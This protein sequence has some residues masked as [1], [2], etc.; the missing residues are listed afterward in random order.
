MEISVFTKNYSAPPINRKEILRY[1]KAETETEELKKLIDE[2]LKE[3]ETALCYKVV[4]CELPICC[5]NGCL[6]LKF[7][8]SYS[9]S[10]CKNLEGCDRIVL[11]AAT[12]GVKFD[13]LT[14]KYNR[15]SPSKAVCLQA[16]GNERIE[17]LCDAFN[18]DM[19]AKFGLTKPRFSPGY[20]D[21]PLSLQKHIFAVLDCHRKIGLTLNESILMSPQKSV[22]AIIGIKK[23]LE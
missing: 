11:F 8:K 10:L 3:A 2:A 18:S 19:T 17:S 13:M 16:I 7:C 20:G 23:N 12:V 4:F 15:I 1:L 22:T 21:L 6:D 9:K 14:E 5:D